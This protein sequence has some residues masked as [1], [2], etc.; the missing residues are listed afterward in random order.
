MENR[1][2]K[3]IP[4]WD[5]SPLA[6]NCVT[7]F[8]AGIAGLTAAHELV[9]RGFQVQV[10]EKQT[11]QRRPERGCDVGGMAR[12]QWGSTPWALR[13]RSLGQLPAFTGEW[14]HRAVQPISPIPYRFYIRWNPGVFRIHDASW[15][16]RTSMADVVRKAVEEIRPNIGHGRIASNVRI[17]ITVKA[18]GVTELSPQ[19]RRR[20]VIEVCLPLILDVD[21]SWSVVESTGETDSQSLS[22]R[23]SLSLGPRM[24]ILPIELEIVSSDNADWSDV[25][26][27]LLGAEG[28]ASRVL[29]SARRHWDA[30]KPDSNGITAEKDLQAVLELVP[31]PADGAKETT[32]YI[33]AAA[34]HLAKVSNA[35][36]RHCIR[37]AMKQFALLNGSIDEALQNKVGFD[38]DY[39]SPDPPYPFD[40][41]VDK[42]IRFVLVGIDSFPYQLYEDVAEDI[43]LVIG[44]R[45]RERW[46]PG[47]HGYRFFPSC[48]HH[49]FDTMK[50]TPI[51]DVSTKS[52]YALAQERAAGIKHP[53]T[54]E[55]VETGRTAFDNLHP[56]STHVLA[57]GAGQRPSQ[58]SR[59][60]VRSF[61]ELREYVS[62]IFGSRE[63]G[64]FD[65]DPRDVARLTMKV[66]QFATSCEGRRQTYEDE[67]WWDY[68]GADTMT[69]AA[70][71][72]L[73]K[74]PR[75]LV[76]MSA[77]E[78]D[79][80][81]HWVMF[82]QLLLDQVR[83]AGQDNY[84]D[85][86]LRGPTSEAWLIPWRRYLEAQGV[87]FI[88]GEITGFRV[89]DVE[90][91]EADEKNRIVG[92]RVWPTVTCRDPRYP[93]K[94]A[95]EV[96]PGYF[97][98]AVSADAAR[99]LAEKYF[100]LE[101]V[102]R[103]NDDV[104]DFARVLDVGGVADLG[105]ALTAPHPEGDFRHF[106]GIQ[107]YFAEDVYW[108]DGHVYYPDSKWGLTSISQARFWQDKMD[109][110][111]GYRGILSVIIGKWDEPGDKIE[112]PAWHCTPAELAEEV[113]D[114][115][116]KSIEGTRTRP[117]DAIGPFARRTPWD[118]RLPEPILWHVDQN[119]APRYAGGS[120]ESYQNASPFY[121]ARPGRF[122][123]R[124]GNLKDGYVVE[125]GFVF[126]G[127]YT[128]TYTRVPSMEAANESGRHAV[129]AILRHIHKKSSE[130]DGNSDGYLF[131][132]SY[133]D[134]WNPEDRE[135]DDLQFL[136]DLDEELLRRGRPHVMELFE[137]DYLAE[138]LLR[139]GPGDP[140][141]P[142]QLL[143]RLRTLYRR[144]SHRSGGPHGDEA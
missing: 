113:W 98:L 119:L 43:D 5:A 125:H 23:F 50:R 7:I 141:D 68:I 102:S 61:E 122:R 54:L 121:I 46:I 47:E 109:W 81:T 24:Q 32:V 128:Q 87:E 100:D 136:R 106:A 48:Y 127:Y 82:I 103:V 137:L 72:L 124:P 116:R 41:L 18:Y 93:D 144:A 34:R 117:G 53:E 37:G 138:H 57:F 19:E 118:G 132:R 76:A 21:K 105:G 95:P 3:D 10:W 129:N 142:L 55:Y 31:R 2:K 67:S 134:V 39:D 58:L 27:E 111:H 4:D 96:R 77:E 130:Q 16:G 139:G 35:E 75:A 88:H 70:K 114:Q 74:W 84:R 110:E 60:S 65:L 99:S 79:A 86:T 83:Q 33:E 91:E 15:S 22:Y 78:S 133:C 9:E 123:S 126:A 6:P 107:F 143:S 92:R 62:V 12:T 97:V 104:S 90:D 17:R 28:A 51:L 108:I 45:L 42:R 71:E 11:D 20:R 73:R 89:L 64:G 120:V 38:V 29:L 36:L 112:K 80:R 25:V 44:F 56:T 8:G 94:D 140:L 49:V 52:Q 63:S 66:L 69:D 1:E 115:I 101:N 30:Q 131:R 13:Q 59:Y 85:G 14:G 26:V 40:I 135:I